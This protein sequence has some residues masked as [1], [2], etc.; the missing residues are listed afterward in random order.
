M[1]SNKLLPGEREKFYRRQGA[2]FSIMIVVITFTFI[3]GYLTCYRLKTHE[4]VKILLADAE[5]PEYCPV[6]GYEF[7]YVYPFDRTLYEDYMERW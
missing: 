3:F 5:R 1:L 6:C 2:M 4:F 7:N